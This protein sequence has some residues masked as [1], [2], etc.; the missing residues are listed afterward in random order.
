MRA[1]RPALERLETTIADLFS[2]H[3]EHD[4]WESFPGA[5]QALAPRL[6]LALGSDRT[7]FQDASEAQQ[8]SGIAPVMERSGKFCWG[9]WRWACP[10]FL[11]Q[12][13]HEFAAHSIPWSGW[14]KAYYLQQ[15]SRGLGHHAAL[16]ALAFKWLRILY[17]CWQNRTLYDERVHLKPLA[18]RGSPLR[19]SMP[20]PKN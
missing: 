17:R 3:P 6:L 12:S 2:Q 18:R 14:A 10:K 20:V 8:F 11:G 9:H 7:R 13:F 5:G 19:L 4:L 16:R 1:L 15:R